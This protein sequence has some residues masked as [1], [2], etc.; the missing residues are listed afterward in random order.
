MET[1]LEK[2]EERLK[3]LNARVEL[4]AEKNIQIEIKVNAVVAQ[5]ELLRTALAAITKAK[6][7]GSAKMIAQ[8]ALMGFHSF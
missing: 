2:L 6:G 8:N 1:E 4:A 3:E 7:L 5:N